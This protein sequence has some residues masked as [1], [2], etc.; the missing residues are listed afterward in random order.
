M[1]AEAKQRRA[2]GPREE[3]WRRLEMLV[4][5][6]AGPDCRKRDHVRDVEGRDRRLT[7]IGVGVAGQRPEPGF[8]PLIVSTMQVKSRP[9]M[10]FST[11]RSFSSA[12]RGSL[13]QTVT[14]A[15]M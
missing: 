13:S 4:A 7:D 6:R 12:L 1:E 8:H 10:T 2:F 3:Q 15:V 14:V 5:R 9:W 11:R